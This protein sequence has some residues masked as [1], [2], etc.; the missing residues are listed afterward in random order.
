[1]KTPLN[2]SLA[3]LPALIMALSAQGCFFDP[4]PG[5]SDLAGHEIT[6]RDVLE[7]GEDIV[8]PTEDI[9]IPDCFNLSDQGCWPDLPDNGDSPDLPDIPDVTDTDD[10]G[11]DCGQVLCIDCVCEC[12]DDRTF[13]YGGCFDDCDPPPKYLEECRADCVELCGFEPGRNCQWDQDCGDGLRCEEIPCPKCGMRPQSVC[14]PLPCL[15]N[16]CWTDGDCRDEGRRCYGQQVETATMGACLIP[17]S[18]AVGC[19]TDSECPVDSV[20]E[21]PVHNDPC[22]ISAAA[23]FPGTCTGTGAP[24]VLLWIADGMYGPGETLFPIWY[25]FTAEPVFLGGCD[26]FAIEQKDGDSW[27]SLGSTIDCVW[28]GTAREIAPGQAWRAEDFRAPDDMGSGA[29]NAYRLSGNYYTGCL[30]DKPLS[31]SQCT[32][33]PFP[34]LSREY[35]VGLAP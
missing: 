10:I 2:L 15:P 20:C 8:E 33:G 13:M 25:N 18:E 14:V 19:W 32:A 9:V 27:K 34:V 22:R 1:M 17:P 11:P 31:Q 21:N 5:E 23:E 29:M 26:T 24:E 3:L 4:D 16:G 7:G 35:S 12:E 6:E 30:S 28:E